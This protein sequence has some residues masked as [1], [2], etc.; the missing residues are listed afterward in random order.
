MAIH[1]IEGA[2]CVALHSKTQFFLF[3]FLF[4]SVVDRN[5]LVAAHAIGGGH[6][7]HRRRLVLHVL[8][9]EVALVLLAHGQ[10]AEDQAHGHDACVA[11]RRR[12]RLAHHRAQADRRRE[13][14]ISRERK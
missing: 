6:H 4:R 7:A 3:L 5:V 2:S 9:D 12:Q 10:L 1:K 13:P 14:L 8:S 11:R